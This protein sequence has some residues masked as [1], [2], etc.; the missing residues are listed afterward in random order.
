MMSN[1]VRLGLQEQIIVSINFEYF[2]FFRP[3]MCV[4]IYIY[5]YLVLVYYPESKVE[6]LDLTHNNRLP[7]A[8]QF[9]DPHWHQYLTSLKPLVCICE[10]TLWMTS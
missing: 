8:L 2:Y 1:L 5:I 9:D 10:C 3:Y 7:F 6:V 4:Y